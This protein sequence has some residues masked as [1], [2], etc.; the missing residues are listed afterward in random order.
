M[1]KQIEQATDWFVQIGELNWLIEAAIDDLHEFEKASGERVEA[2]D[3]DQPLLQQLKNIK[4]AAHRLHDVLCVA[5]IRTAFSVNRMNITRQQYWLLRAAGLTFPT[6]KDLG[7]CNVDD[8]EVYRNSIYE[9]DVMVCL[10][11]PNEK[12][13]STKIRIRLAMSPEELN[14][15]N[16][17]PKQKEFFKRNRPDVLERMQKE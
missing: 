7:I 15:K 10:M 13:G 4:A 12:T 17:R 6:A 5:P 3:S 8:Y 9:D 14:I 2:E 11:D 1:K 16:L